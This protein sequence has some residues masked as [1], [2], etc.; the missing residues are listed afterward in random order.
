MRA[1]LPF[2]A[3]A[4]ALLAGCDDCPQTKCAAP[5]ALEIAVTDA[6]TG[7]PLGDAKVS[8][9]SGG[10]AVAFTFACGE[11]CKA[12]SAVGSATVTVEATGYQAAQFEVTI[13]LDDCDRPITQ[14]REVGLRLSG[15]TTPPTILERAG[16]PSC[17]S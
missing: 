17:G 16:A 15:A 11:A 13:P 3:V 8:A 5:P 2:L 7:A 6:T 12:G 9:I 1:A 14:R 4:A 10:Q